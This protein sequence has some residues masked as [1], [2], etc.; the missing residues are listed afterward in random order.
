MLK[1]IIAIFSLIVGGIIY[2]LWRSSTLLMFT[3]IEKFNL[4]NK[5]DSLRISIS[6]TSIF[7]PN[8]VLYSLPNALWLL[9]GLLLFFYIWDNNYSTHRNFWVGLFLFASF[10]SEFGQALSIIPGTF[11]W[12]DIIFMCI[13]VICAFLIVGNNKNGDN[14]E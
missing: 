5:V 10:G 9:S 8:W 11:D 6:E 3:W 2:L 13:A 12:N 1:I 14:Y 7:L 4:Y